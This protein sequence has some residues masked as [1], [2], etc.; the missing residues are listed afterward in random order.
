MSLTMLMLAA[1]LL[2]GQDPKTESQK[3]W[4]SEGCSFAL[5]EQ[6]RSREQEPDLGFYAPDK[7]LIGKQKTDKTRAKSDAKS[8]AIASI[9][10][11][12]KKLRESTDQELEREALGKI[13][14]A[15]LWYKNVKWLI[16]QLSVEKESVPFPT[17]ENQ[18]GK[19]K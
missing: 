14:R 17:H 7:R 8:Q 11:N 2:A 15:V 18:S 9:E 10:A 1:A 3:G 6:A 19:K 5:Q 16:E 12:L 4:I 13:E